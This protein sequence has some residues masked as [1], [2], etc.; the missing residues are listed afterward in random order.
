MKITIILAL[1]VLFFQS[2]SFAEELPVSDETKAKGYS[3]Y[4]VLECPKTSDQMKN[5]LK[6]IQTLKDS[7]KKEARCEET[8]E[9]TLQNTNKL[10]GLVGEQRTKFLALM[11]KGKSEGLN[12]DEQAEIQ[13]YVSNLMTSTDALVRVIS[14]NS[15]CFEEDKKASSLSLITSLIGEGSKILS[16]V[17]GPAV[18]GTVSIASNLVVGFLEGMKTMRENSPGFR[19]DDYNQ[20]E[21]YSESL[22]SLFDYKKEVRNF[23]YP[24]NTI[25]N[26][27][28]LD[29]TLKK[30]IK[31]LL[32]NCVECKELFDRIAAAEAGRTRAEVW[33][34][35]FE[36]EMK[37][38]AAE[39]NKKYVRP[40]GTHTYRSLRTIAWV[41]ERIAA[42]SN[43]QIRADLGLQEIVKQVA[44]IENFMIS[45]QSYVFLMYQKD[46]ARKSFSHLSAQMGSL[47]RPL[48]RELN[49]TVEPVRTA[50]YPFENYAVRAAESY[51]TAMNDAYE[52]ADRLARGKIET[53]AE[54]ID[55]S[56]S[57]AIVNIG[58]VDRY[59][60]FFLNAR[61]YVRYIQ[62][63]CENG[64]FKNWRTDLDSLLYSRSLL[65]RIPLASD[66]EYGLREDSLADNPPRRMAAPPSDPAA[67]TPGVP[68]QTPV[69][70]NGGK[71]N[72]IRVTQDWA[73]SLE[74][75][76]DDLIDNPDYVRRTA[77]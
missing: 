11:E 65:N 12:K 74:K 28:R 20:R 73:E 48:L 8:K 24:Q 76:V 55:S 56:L 41:K 72:G 43:S 54:Q 70:S 71:A 35:S 40:L 59:C 42:L 75:T 25:A 16:L 39:V 2:F 44:D 66:L 3:P 26:L 10:S 14:G 22:C 9:T 61:W 69:S 50:H 67:R 58:V 45:Q 19:F 60:A 49:Q 64:E 34:K 33:T 77:P 68:T 21:A 4:P 17:G 7:I 52:K 15:T 1:S 13:N 51:M 32:E 29:E 23:I 63:E 30:Q 31:I 5:L 46:L 38:L 27:R 36:D 37:R 53:L 18:A 6:R 47:P 62:S 57:Q